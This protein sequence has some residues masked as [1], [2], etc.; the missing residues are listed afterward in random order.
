MK[1]LQEISTNEGNGMYGWDLINPYL[2]DLYQNEEE[3]DNDKIPQYTVPL[4]KAQTNVPFEPRTYEPTIPLKPDYPV[5]PDPNRPTK[6][7]EPRKLRSLTEGLD[8]SGKRIWNDLKYSRG[9]IQDLLSEDK[10]DAAKSALEHLPEYE[11]STDAQLQ[12]KADSLENVPKQKPVDQ[13]RIEL[14]G[15]KEYQ[16]LREDGLPQG[17]IARQLSETARW[18]TEGKR[19]MEEARATEN[20]FPET[21]GWATAGSFLADVSRTGIPVAIGAASA[22]AG[23]AAGALNVGTSVLQ[24]HAQAQM[25]LDNYEEEIGQPLSSFQRTAYTAICMGADFLFDTILQSRY[26]GNLKSGIKRQ[27][28]NYFKKELLKNKAAQKEAKQLLRNLSY[29]DKSGVLLGTAKDAAAGSVS[30]GLNSVAHDMGQMVYANPEDYPTLNSI[31]QN[32][33]MGMATGGAGGAVAGGI[34]RV[35]NLHKKNIRRNQQEATAI[36]NQDGSTWE[37][38]DYDPESRSATVIS[39]DRRKPV[40]IYDVDPDM[41]RSLSTSETRRDIQIEKEINEPDPLST[42][43]R[44]PAK[45]QAWQEMSLRGKYLLTKDLVDRMG[46]DN[47][48]IYER[49]ADIPKPILRIKLDGARIGGFYRHNGS[50]GIVLENLPSYEMLQH[51]LLHEAVGHR[52]LNA[53]FG[54]TYFKDEFLMRIYDS[55]PSL[56]KL[57][58]NSWNARTNDAEEYLA[59][60]AATGRHTPAWRQICADLR[61]MLRIFMPGLRFSNDELA[62]IISLSRN[63]LKEDYSI[64]EMNQRI[65]EQ[66]G[67][68]YYEELGKPLSETEKETYRL[69]WENDPQWQRYKR[70]YD[71]VY[72]DPENKRSSST[73]TDSDK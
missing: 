32:A 66:M 70:F 61:G 50:I 43:L 22:P 67:D 17:E 59:D 2:Q 31:L 69:L 18:G 73:P 45:D 28:S 29:S 68:E 44:D 20:A 55:I 64:S 7:P 47:V 25:E 72:G 14:E 51:V 56:W 42:V 26:L 41:I 46:V 40:T 9:Y 21:E 1:S 60:L 71:E 53:L 35:S 23:I 4:P 37:V 63:A 48:F 52:G 15:L 19:I 58:G 33:A 54:S 39:P 3:S 11:N 27:A 49:E 38:L 65:R 16:R 57:S 36:L 5:N 8:L 62:D 34:G 24:S 12:H 6:K 10:S 13:P 30:E